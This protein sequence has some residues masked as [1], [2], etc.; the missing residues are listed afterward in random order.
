[1]PCG[2]DFQG[3]VVDIMR[4]DSRP[5]L[6]RW[7]LTVAVLLAVMPAFSAGRDREA[8]I[9]R[10]VKPLI[11]SQ[12]IPGVAVGIYENGKATV[13][14]FGSVGGE[15]A[16]KPNGRTIYEVGSISKV[17]TG[18]LLAEAVQRGEVGLDDPLSK[19]LPNGVQAPKRDGKEILLWHLAT[20]TSGL[21]RIPSNMAATDLANPY[22]SYD[23]EKLWSAIGGFRPATPMG[24]TY[25]YSNLGVGLLGTL[26][27][28]AADKPYER[29][30]RTRIAKPLK[31]KD[32]T[33]VLSRSQKKRLAPPRAAGG[34]PTSNWDFDC[35]V[36]CGGVRSTVDDMLK[37]VA[38][39]LS[40]KSDGIHDAIKL[41]TE[42]KYTMPG[43]MSGIGLGWQIAQ[44]GST[45]WHNG[46]TGGYH[47][48]LF[49]DRLKHTGV[50]VLANG[51]EPQVSAVAESIIQLLAGI[52]VKPPNVR[53]HIAVPVAKLDRLVGEYPSSFRFT[54]SI[55]REGDALMARLTNQTAMRVF[56]ESPT[57]FFYRDVEAELEFEMDLATDR[58]TAVT[59]FQN[60]RKFRCVRKK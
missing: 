17:F 10:L 42:R 21:P 14:G 24:E 56:P 46:Q 54:I 25:A 31:M 53:S 47:S 57:L 13:F 11:D 20:H 19:H 41:S 51:A 32:T 33:T 52:E 9:G 43:L 28:R 55:T 45:L 59:L 60:G 40:D 50:V 3:S 1:M 15:K 49:V 36:G 37:L 58:A 29:L 22:A 18:V 48:G 44:D 16:R 35:L 4:N 38:A 39:T 8:E 30:L 2:L 5:L 6:A 12:L 26:L 27:S 7:I 34:Q 23:R